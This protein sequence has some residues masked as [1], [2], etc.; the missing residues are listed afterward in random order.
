MFHM[1]S[2]SPEH[3][4][5]LVV[6]LAEEQV[7]R[8]VGDPYRFGKLFFLAAV[9]SVADCLEVAPL[10]MDHVDPLDLEPDYE[11]KKILEIFLEIFLENFLE[12]PYTRKRGKMSS[13]DM[14]QNQNSISRK[15]SRKISRIFFSS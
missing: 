7:E 9:V 15:I 10:G 13:L 11:E 8:D 1:M 4:S 2:Y 6:E 14:S 12:I 3:L 5:S